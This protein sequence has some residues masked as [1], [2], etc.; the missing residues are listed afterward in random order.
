MDLPLTRRGVL[1][2]LAAAPAVLPLA[3]SGGLRPPLASAAGPLRRVS[4]AD[5]VVRGKLTGAAAVVEALKAEGCPC[6]FGI[7]GAQEN[8]LWD[9]MKTRGLPYLLV[10]HEF[11]A[12]CM[13]DAVGRATGRPGVLCV[14][15][16]P[17]VTNSLTGLGE[18]LLDSS[19]VVAIVGDVARGHDY[20]PF[21]VHEMD[22]VALLKPVTKAV[23]AVEHAAQIADAVR[24]AFATAVCGEPGPVAV[25]IPYP[26]LL[27]VHHYD[28]P[29]AAGPGQ[30]FDETAFRAALGLLGDRGLRI[31]IYAGAGCMDHGELLLQAAEI[32]QAPVA[33][34]VSGKGCI[35]E[36][37][38]LAVGWGYGPQGTHAA[39]LAFRGITKL[40][41]HGVECVLAIGVKYSEVSTGFYSQ[42]QTK[43]VIHVDAS[44][45]NLGRVL[46]TDVKV[47]ADAGAF[48]SQLVANA[49]CVRRPPDPH[50]VGRIAKL[51][52]D[53]ARR[54]CPL[55]VKC[56]V[57][58]LAVILALRRHLPDDGM[59][60]V[61]VTMAE[62][63]AAEVYT[64]TC[65]RTYFNP[66]DNQS[67][68]WSVPASLGAQR[69]F[70]GRAVATLTGDGC[71]L[72]SAMEVSTAARAGLPV[73]FFVLDDQAYHYMQTLQKPAYLQTTATILARIDY[74]ALA[75]ALG[76]AYLEVRDGSQLEGAVAGAVAH[77]G[78]VLVRVVTDYGDRKVRWI[79]AVRDRFI[80]ELSARQ[81][82][83]FL[84]RVGSRAA[85]FK[86]PQND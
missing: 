18:A 26:L 52:A 77:C 46:R 16:G 54:L 82:A 42:P 19:P 3:A 55:P 11:S 12:A 33:T 40:G 38:P 6:V 9:A 43:R 41:I 1:Q 72:F 48:L 37:H 34:S 28:S 22:Q 85:D 84:A 13:A 5:G 36:T 4:H 60:F 78:P 25:V 83:R 81:K 65:P 30:P 74:A 7:P 67:M 10:T 50:L 44:E 15:P 14:V 47:H 62:H 49:D 39:E 59:L 27:E 73:K 66:T 51:K 29:P 79:E 63:L 75:Q 17:G 2:A 20:R 76:V 35:P 61:D 64:V 70:P 45:C 69:V 31:G 21:Q 68:G 71:F 57:D 8:E 23:Y 80:D 56:G 53:D 24:A 32:L 58:P 86:P